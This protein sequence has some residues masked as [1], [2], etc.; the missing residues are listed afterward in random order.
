M[1]TEPI[2]MSG[3]Y[4]TTTNSATFIFTGHANGTLSDGYYQA[5]VSGSGVTDPNGKPLPSNYTVNFFHLTADANHDG[6]VN[7]ADFS[8]L[9]A[10]YGQ[11]S[12]ANFSTGDFNYDGTVN[13][14]DFNAL[15]TKYGTVLTA[16]SNG[17]LPAAV[18]AQSLAASRIGSSLSA[19]DAATL[20]L[21]SN[22]SITPTDNLTDV[23]R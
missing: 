14:L 16:P 22:E 19:G 2:A 18:T 1:A 4:N 13:A 12:G 7:A 17:D 6:T 5:V 3:S 9:A 23:I 20:N 15:A 8:I 11:T 21:F 10:H